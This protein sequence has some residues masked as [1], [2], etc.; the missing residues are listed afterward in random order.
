MQSASLYIHIPWC[1]RKCPY[2]DFNAHKRPDVINERQYVEHLI[3]DFEQDIL[4]FGTRSIS[5]IFIGGGTPSLFSAQAYQQLFENLNRINPLS[6]TIEITMEANPGTAEQIKFAGYR[7]AGIN[8][9]SLGIQSF[10]AEHLKKLGRVH[11]DHQAHKAIQVARDAGFDNINLDIMH[12]L[13]QQTAAQGIE[14]LEIALAYQPEHLSWYQLTLEPNTAFYKYP[15]NI[16][17]EDTLYELET[18]GLK[19]LQHKQFKRYE[20]SAY[21]R[22]DLIS[23]H[24]QNY[25]T[26]GDYFGIGAG[27]HG[28][29]SSLNFETITRTQKRRQPAAYQNPSKQYTC[30][31]QCLTPKDIR[32]EY[33]LNTT[34][35]E[36]THRMDHFKQQT[37]QPI[38]QLLPT[39]LLAANKGFIELENTHW[40]VSERG[41]KF[42]NELQEMFL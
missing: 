3:Q 1:I 24:N 35:L 8:R 21:C 40:R 19:L 36:Q 32:F 12:G 34:R 4:Q 23:Q 25:W 6:N 11:D 18:S 17:N 15:P 7:S 28:K 31:R 37:G 9:L 22:S 33:M 29:I 26:F 39:L 20:I 41:R 42:S 14:D 5:S 13:P 30:K 2:C 38:E 16:P 10:N 27:A